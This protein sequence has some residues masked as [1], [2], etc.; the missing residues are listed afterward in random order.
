MPVV[1]ADG[2]AVEYKA[3]FNAANHFN[4]AT[5][6]GINRCAVTRSVVYAAMVVVFGKHAVVVALWWA[7]GAEGI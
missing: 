4:P 1:D 7:Q 2:V 5:S 6:R 3:V